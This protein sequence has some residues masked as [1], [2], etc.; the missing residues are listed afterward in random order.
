MPLAPA[1]Q[2]LSDTHHVLHFAVNLWCI[3]KL[4]I[5][6]RELFSEVDDF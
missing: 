6:V 1:K 5:S 2:M 3:P 4:H